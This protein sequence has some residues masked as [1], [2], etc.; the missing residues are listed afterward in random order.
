[1]FVSFSL[2][3]S[4]FL[5]LSLT[6]FF[7]LPFFLFFSF[8]SAYINQYIHTGLK[9]RDNLFDHKRAL[10]GE[11]SAYNAFVNDLYACSTTE[12]SQKREIRNPFKRSLP[13][14][15]AC[16]ELKDLLG[17]CGPALYGGMLPWRIPTADTTAEISSQQASSNYQ[18]R[19]NKPY[20][21]I[22][23]REK[24]QPS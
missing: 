1:M 5:S 8:H 23:R 15:Q 12:L 24:L 9:P 4:V 3:L 16:P 20:L 19:M 17:Y 11:Q 2:F 13:Y 6:V 22:E 7:S 14:L 21:R 18:E 10:K